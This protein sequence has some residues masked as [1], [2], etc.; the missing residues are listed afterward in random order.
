MPGVITVAAMF[1][2]AQRNKA[3]HRKAA[4]NLTKLQKHDP[5]QFTQEFISLLRRAMVVKQKAP[6]VDR[7]IQ[8]A[9]YFAVTTP[10]P[11]QIGGVEQPFYALILKFMIQISVAKTA[12]ARFRACQCIANIIFSLSE[13]TELDDDLYEAALDAL[14][15]R[16][17]D[18]DQ[19]TRVEAARAL[20]RFQDPEE[21]HCTVTPLFLRML[22]NDSVTAVRKQ[23]LNSVNISKR[24]IGTI[25]GR[26]RDK[27]ADIRKHAFAVLKSKVDVRALTIKQRCFVLET[28]LNDREEKVKEECAKM[29]NSWYKSRGSDVLE[30]L[31]CLHIELNESTA[32]KALLC[33]LK[34][35]D[36]DQSVHATIVRKTI[37]EAVAKMN[38]NE[39]VLLTNEMAFFWRVYC[40]FFDHEVE[41]DSELYLPEVARYCALIL[42][43]HQL[44]LETQEA[45][46][47]HSDFVITQLLKLA[48]K[49]YLG[50]EAQRRMFSG[51][52][53]DLLVSPETPEPLVDEFMH[54]LNAIRTPEESIAIA[55]DNISRIQEPLAAMKEQM[56]DELEKIDARLEEMI[57][58]MKFLKKLKARHIAEENF[59]KAKEAKMDMRALQEEARPLEEQRDL[60]DN[61]DEYVNHRSLHILAV[62][63]TTLPTAMENAQVQSMDEEIVE[64]GL[65]H[66]SFDV[67]KAALECRALFCFEDRQ[68]AKDS[69]KFFTDVLQDANQD[70]QVQLAAMKSVFDLM[71]VYSVT[72]M[73][74]AYAEALEAA[75]EAAE[76][77]SGELVKLM[78]QY[79]DFD[80]DSNVLLQRQKEGDQEVTEAALERAALVLQ[81][82]SA[83]VDG[84]ARLYFLEGISPD[85]EW[86]DRVLAQLVLLFFS[87]DTAE[88]NEIRQCLSVF[89][90]AFTSVGQ[91]H[92]FAVFERI[93]MPTLRVLFTQHLPTKGKRKRRKGAIAV[94]EE[95]GEKAVG[96]V[97]VASEGL[98][99]I[100]YKEIGLFFLDVTAPREDAPLV[101]EKAAIH[102][103]LALAILKDIVSEESD[104]YTPKEFKALT[105]LLS[106]CCLDRATTATLEGISALVQEALADVLTDR[107]AANTAKKVAEALVLLKTAAEERESAAEAVEGETEAETET[108]T[109]IAPAQE[110]EADNTAVASGAEGEARETPAD[111][112]SVAAAAGAALSPLSAPESP[113]KGSEENSP[114]SSPVAPA[115]AK[116]PTKGRKP[117]QRRAAKAAPEPEPETEESDE[118]EIAL[119]HEEED[120][121]ASPV[122]KQRA[123]RKP[124]PAAAKRRRGAAKKAVAD[125]AE[126]EQEAE[127]AEE[128]TAQPKP[129]ARE[130]MG[131][132]EEKEAKKEEDHEEAEEKAPPAK[133]A[134]KVATRRTP[135]KAATARTRRTKATATAADTAATATAAAA[136]PAAAKEAGEEQLLPKKR[137]AA[138]SKR[139]PATTRRKK[140]VPLAEQPP[141]SKPA[142]KRGPLKSVFAL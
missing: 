79:L 109:D 6:S 115:S 89:F 25:L 30:F 129:S 55:L 77:E 99:E 62:L 130:E 33:I 50:D 140:P 38:P 14:E 105:L 19:S 112:P 103:R 104:S 106:K 126:E 101:A 9:V 125:D 39:P 114:A 58:E 20:S 51:L 68:K 1:D 16:A 134:R 107:T 37:V 119:A 71:T 122:K 63:A 8:F 72:D 61:L 127:A 110:G 56:G 27:N 102:D 95:E 40:E 90:S 57:K 138:A 93:F 69:I 13:D 60:H 76:G 42:F 131:E 116:Q 74:V 96:V 67:V 36:L 128:K 132:E 53:C 118:E 54:L 80:G 18:K 65:S 34:D 64:R 86:Y 88:Q 98:K 139:A 75:G 12:A 108:E 82:R 15:I 87:S 91:E 84:F 100:K 46:R 78:V 2:R 59:E 117:L 35:R 28:G 136:E 5:E 32:E 23:V 48:H 17:K 81:F 137:P 120:A 21:P 73:H 4:H 141:A 45:H 11:A 142:I 49:L 124:R 22:E 97:A 41:Q 31:R 123:T 52:L 43:H 24:T 111:T 26:T 85:N 66:D 70:P 92:H 44:D 113:V 47:S 29:L 135:R 10:V 7:V 121:K 133:P 83:A 3:T 94:E